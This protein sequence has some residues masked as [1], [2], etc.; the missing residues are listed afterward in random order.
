MVIHPISMNY[1]N[2]VFIRRFLW[3]ASLFVG[4]GLQLTE[5]S[6]YLGL[7]I[8]YMWGRDIRGTICFFCSFLFVF[9]RGAI[10]DTY[11]IAFKMP[12]KNNL[13]I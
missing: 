3:E 2:S 4:G 12:F 1:G 8:T 11:K 5:T 9:L 13:F 6:S 7:L 10:L